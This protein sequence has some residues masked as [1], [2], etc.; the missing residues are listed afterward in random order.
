M[1]ASV[2]I[3][4]GTER[5]GEGGGGGALPIGVAP[6]FGYS[7]FPVIILTPVLGVLSVME[8][9]FKSGF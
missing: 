4:L 3:E 2:S 9:A 6:R 7:A 8:G 1:C 5:L